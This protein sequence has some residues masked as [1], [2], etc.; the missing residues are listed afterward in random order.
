VTGRTILVGRLQAR[1]DVL[2]AA[3][4]A[5]DRPPMR[6]GGAVQSIVVSPDGAT[7]LAAAGAGVHVIDP[8][9]WRVRRTWPVAG[10][11]KQAWLYPAGGPGRSSRP[12]GSSASGDCTGTVAR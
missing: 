2:D 5:A 10:D 7:V 4:R 11:P 1:L 9:T 6:P 12:M 8:A 3:D